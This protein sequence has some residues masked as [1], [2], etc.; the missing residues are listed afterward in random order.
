MFQSNICRSSIGEVWQDAT[1]DLAQKKALRWLSQPLALLGAMRAL[2]AT[3]TTLD[4]AAV[5]EPLEQIHYGYN[6]YVR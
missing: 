4:Y 6:A 3:V 5:G 1:N 2:N